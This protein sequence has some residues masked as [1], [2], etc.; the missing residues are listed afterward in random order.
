[1]LD[2]NGTGPFS[3]SVASA[4]GK[5]E[6]LMTPRALALIARMRKSVGART[7]GAKL[8]LGAGEHLDE[9][10]RALAE[11]KAI[12]MRYYSLSRD[13]E[14]ERRVDP[15]HVTHVDGGVYLVAHCHLRG[16]VRVFAVE[17]IRTLEVLRDTFTMPA[18]FDASAYLRGAWA[19]VRGD[20][21]TVRAVFDRVAAPH[22][23]GRLWHTSQELR[24]LPGGRLEVRLTVADTLEVRRWLLGF[25]A[26][27]QVLAPP[28]LREAIRREAEAVALASARKLPARAGGRARRPPISTSLGRSR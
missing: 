15:Y 3:A 13:A 23:R 14:T 20:L 7:V 26:A 17:R 2:R 21:I 10:H 5:I 16:E 25:G 28:T 18:G 11:G 19:I 1:M 27:V 8:Q 24:E 12:R 4:F 9:I 6:A 22:V